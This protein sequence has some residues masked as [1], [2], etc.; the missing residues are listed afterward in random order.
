MRHHPV[1]VSISGRSSGN[2]SGGTTT[3]CV[4]PTAFQKLG[5][6]AQAAVAKVSNKTIGVGLGGSAAAG[7]ILGVAFNYSR[8]LVVSPNGQAA[9]TTT[10]TPLNGVPFNA[11]VSPGAGGYGWVAGT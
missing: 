1:H 4:K 9:F 6:A 2:T 3:A 11:L 10:F 8:Q 7:N 5:I